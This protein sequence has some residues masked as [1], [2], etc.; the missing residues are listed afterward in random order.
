MADAFGA[1]PS[2][3]DKAMADAFGAEPSDADKAMA[4]TLGAEPELGSGI[5]DLSGELDVEE[6][7]TTPD[8]ADTEFAGFNAGGAEDEKLPSLDAGLKNLGAQA[9]AEPEDEEASLSQALAQASAQ[10]DAADADAA[11]AD[12]S[13]TELE[14]LQDTFNLPEDSVSDIAREAVPQTASQEA[15]DLADVLGTSLE[16][17]DLKEPEAPSD[18]LLSADETFDADGVG[19]EPNPDFVDLSHE[20]SIIPGDNSVQGQDFKSFGLGDAAA[21][22]VGE[23]AALESDSAL[24]SAEP[25]ADAALAEDGAHS[26][27]L[28]GTSD[29]AAVSDDELF[30]AADTSKGDWEQG[31]AHDEEPVDDDHDFVNFANNL[32][33][34]NEDVPAADE[35][36][37]IDEANTAHD[38]E[39]AAAAPDLAIPE[40]PE[41]NTNASAEHFDADESNAELDRIEHD[42]ESAS[43]AADADIA[44]DGL[45]GDLDGN[46]DELEADLADPDLGGL[47]SYDATS[48]YD[49]T[50]DEENNLIMPSAEEMAQAQ[51]E[52]GS[53]LEDL[54]TALEPESTIEPELTEPADTATEPVTETAD[55]EVAGVAEPELA[56]D[57]AEP[58]DAAEELPTQDFLDDVSAH[59]HDIDEELS[60]DDLKGLSSYDKDEKY[61]Q[62]SSDTDLIMPE[63]VAPA[64]SAAASPLD[65]LDSADFDSVLDNIDIPEADAAEAPADVADGAEMPDAAVPDAAAEGVDVEPASPLETERA[66]EVEEPVVVA[67]DAEVADA[68]STEPIEPVQDDTVEDVTSSETELEPSMWSVP[69]D[70]DFDLPHVSGVNAADL[71]EEPAAVVEGEVVPDAAPASDDD[72]SAAGFTTHELD[73][74]DHPAAEAA[75]AAPAAEASTEEL[76]SSEAAEPADLGA[77]F[78]AELDKDL[79]SGSA[80][81]PEPDLEVTN[82]DD[83]LFSSR[84]GSTDA[85]ADMLSDVPADIPEEVVRQSGSHITADHEP[86]NLD[87]QPAAEPAAAPTAET[88]PAAEPEM[89]AEPE[90]VD[91]EVA[92]PAEPEVAADNPSLEEVLAQAPSADS[93]G[94]AAEA[95]VGDM[96]SGSGSDDEL[97]GGDLGLDQSAAAAQSDELMGSM[98]AEPSE[99]EASADDFLSEHALSPEGFTDAFDEAADASSAEPA[100]GDSGDFDLGA[101]DESEPASGYAGDFDLGAL[102]ES[103]PVSGDAG[104]FDLGAMDAAEPASGDAGDFDLGAMDAA[105]PASGDAGDFDLGAMG[106]AEPASGDAGDFDLG[107]MDAAEPASGDAGDFDLDALGDGTAEPEAE[108]DGALDG[109]DFDFD[110]LSNSDDTADGDDLGAFGDLDGADFGA[111][112]A[113]TGDFSDL[114]ADDDSGDFAGFDESALGGLDDL[115]L[116]EPKAPAAPRS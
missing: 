106:E 72:L 37:G 11:D 4:D 49:D 79:D 7:E 88:A 6:P 17:A 8:L 62:H 28:F 52:S 111:E 25:A 63:E 48:P 38:V 90:A 36:K 21:D 60:S 12:H 34:S 18:A 71:V 80:N 93:S 86:L 45:L 67:T 50:A 69:S 30:G 39:L 13:A 40:S 81:W 54:D 15:K 31:F 76:D 104:D 56:A 3:A 110:A 108:L 44:A 92:E 97:L 47:S 113:G 107:A 78:A 74:L 51:L 24:E 82:D 33:R 70:E 41:L 42:A 29:D 43:A 16:H 112:S 61:T 95:I 102:D 73:D 58:E 19:L 22:S 87:A 55:A 26:G 89:A 20:D 35:F 23:P 2:D 116:T 10:R 27:D 83:E 114:G 59:S 91:P 14:A 1:E 64:E 99:G 9:A 32:H 115:D 53:E 100:A 66:H 96:V 101:L 98:M 105:E 68:G 46:K 5:T 84:I 109:A 57:G 75:E 103:E 85:L 94:A 65:E 77:D